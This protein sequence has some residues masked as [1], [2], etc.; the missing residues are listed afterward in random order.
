MELLYLRRTC[1]TSAPFQS[2]ASAPFATVRVATRESLS[3]H[4]H[5]VGGPLAAREGGR[6][7]RSVLLLLLLGDPPRGLPGP[8]GHQL[9]PAGH[10]L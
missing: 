6:G 2:A 9:R 3:P 5:A 7:H 8:G 10:K 4:E 1:L